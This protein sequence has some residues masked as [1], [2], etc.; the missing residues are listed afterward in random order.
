MSNEESYVKDGVARA[1][2]ERRGGFGG[3]TLHDISNMVNTEA[4]GAIFSYVPQYV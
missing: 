2:I 4:L 3:K 1:K